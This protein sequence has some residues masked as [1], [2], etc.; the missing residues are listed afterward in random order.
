MAWDGECTLTNPGA[1]MAPDASGSAAVTLGGRFELSPELILGVIAVESRFDHFA[2]SNVGAI[3]LM[4]VMPFWKDKLGSKDDNLLKIETNIA[5]T[6][7]PACN[8]KAK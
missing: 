2:V 3:G 4:Q 6:I 7:W 8:L 1:V 5:S